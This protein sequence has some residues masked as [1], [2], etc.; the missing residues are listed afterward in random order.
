MRM[1]R[2]R[3]LP[4]SQ[5]RSISIVLINAFLCLP[6]FTGG[7][8]YNQDNLT[9]DMWGYNR[10]TRQEVRIAS[11]FFQNEW[12]NKQW[13]FLLGGRLDKHN[14]VD[15][16][17]FSPRANLRYNPTENMNLR[18][19]YSFGFR[20]PQAFD[21]DLHIENVGGT[22]SMIELAKDLT[23]EKSQK[24]ERIGRFVSSLGRFPRKLAYRRFL[25][26][27]FR[28]ICLTPDRGA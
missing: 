26:F 21:E 12:K 13:S 11:A 3:I 7:L 24:S 4:G 18:A 22:V 6:I 19:S 2:P 23:E 14:M 16:V 8:E 17:I 10:Y 20:A 28:C 1:A 9:D 5:D 27:A 25:Y 15:H